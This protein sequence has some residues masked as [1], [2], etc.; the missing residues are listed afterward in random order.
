[1]LDTA[2]GGLASTLV[3]DG[4]RVLVTDAIMR[5]EADR[6]RLAQEVLAFAGA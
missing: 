2:D 6:A 4:L 3:A 1:V 5:N